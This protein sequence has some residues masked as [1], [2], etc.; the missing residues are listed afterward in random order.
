MVEGI[1]QNSHWLLQ[2]KSDLSLAACGIDGRSWQFVSLP[3]TS[4]QPSA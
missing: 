1:E 4:S 2:W 3:K